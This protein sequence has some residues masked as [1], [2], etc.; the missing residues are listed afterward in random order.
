[1]L[2][3]PEFP[4]T[5]REYLKRYKI[6]QAAAAQALGISQQA[7]SRLLGK[8]T[9]TLEMIELIEEYTEGLVSYH[10][11]TWRAKKEGDMRL[12]KMGKLSSDALKIWK[13]T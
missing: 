9:P 11:F 12:V 1:M 3:I 5:F 8:T 10:S 7:V 13:D 4:M 2:P 6:S